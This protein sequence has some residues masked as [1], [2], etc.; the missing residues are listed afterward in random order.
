M[1]N[2]NSKNCYS[3]KNKSMPYHEKGSYGQVLV[4]VALHYVGFLHNVAQHA[5][6][7]GSLSIVVGFDH[8]YKRYFFFFFSFSFVVRDTHFMGS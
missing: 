6:W 5:I 7:S 3:L 1:L 2:D 4:L 8:G